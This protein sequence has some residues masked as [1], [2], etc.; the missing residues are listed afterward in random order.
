MTGILLGVNLQAQQ[1]NHLHYVDPFIGTTVSNVLTKWGNNG[2]CYPGGVAPSGSMQLSPETRVVGARGYN[3]ADSSIYYFSCLGHMG[4]FPK[5]SSGRLYIM[6]LKGGANFEAGKSSLRFSHKK[7]T[8]RPGY[9]KVYFDDQQIT[10]EA[11]ATT[12]TGI[13][14]FTFDGDANPQIFVGD[15]GEIRAISDKII[16]AS[17]FNAVINFSEGYTDKKEVKGGWL[18]SFPKAKTGVKMITLKLSRSSV[19]S[20]SAQYNIDK[21]AGN[22]SFDEICARTSREWAKL[23]SVVDLNDNNEQNKTVFYTALYHSLLLPWVA[24]DA[25]GNYRG[26]NG[27]IYKKTGQNQYEAF[28]PWDTFRSLHPLL[29]LLYPQKQQD[30]I[31]SMLDI[32][33][34]SGH[35]PTE[36]MTG[37]HAIP[38]IVDSYLKGIKGFDKDFAYKAMKKDLVDGPFV[39]SDME[40]YHQKGYVPF[41]KPESVTRTVEYAYDDW[42]LSQFADKVMND[43]LTYQLLSNRGFNYRNLLN[44]DELFMLPRNGDEFK[45]QPGT[46]GYKEG[47]KWVYSYF[48]PQNGKDLINMTGGNEQFA[49][50]LDSALR[51][52]VI[53]F[54][55]ETVFH[56]PYL[57]NQAGKPWLTQKW[58]KDIMLHRFNATPGG[59]PGNDDLGSTSSWYIFSSL[60]IYPVCPGR[61]LYAIGAPLFKSATLYLPNGKK[62]VISSNNSVLKNNYV[63]SLRINGKAWQQLILPHSVLMSGGTMTFNMG[64]E[65]GSW[66]A[67]KDPIVLSTTQ[68]NTAFNIVN[69][70]VSKKSVVPDEPLVINFKLK[71]TGG[72]GIKTVKLL[73]EGKPYAYKN[74]LV[75][76]GQTLQDSIVFRLY[77][78]GKSILKLDNTVPFI[79]EV[80]LPEK[81][82]ERP[83]EISGLEVKPMIRL[84][85]NQQIRYMIKNTGGLKQTFI[86]PVILNDSVVFNDNIKLNTGEAKIISHNIT[87]TQKGF[88]YLKIDTAKTIYIVYEDGIESLLLDFRSIVPGKAV[89]DSSGFHNNGKIIS[90]SLANNKDRLLFGDS[91]YVEVANSP[92]LNNMGESITMMGWVYPM[93]NEKGLV[94]IITKGDNHVLQMTDNKTLTFFAGGWGRGDCTVNLPVDW[95]QHWHHIAGICNGKKL[96]VYIDGVLAGTTL[97][98]VSAD[99]SVNNKWTLGRNEE[100]PSERV[101]HGYINRVKVFKAALSVNDIKNIVSSEKQ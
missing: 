37:N 68:K 65:P 69:Y 40:V 64:K 13:F 18:F 25:E 63:Q 31:L 50:R 33:K 91:T 29:T 93:G 87:V 84:K 100:F 61:P 11:T 43:K 88:K 83:F 95:Q 16:H 20:N 24:D 55:N 99:L 26:S 75:E 56:L 41:T 51:N 2:G 86:I 28:S 72:K 36:S 32:Y 8:A 62:F 59:L 3:Y 4:G 90:G 101:F 73:V 79:V 10:A 6:P 98:E 78:V 7:E 89:T 47:D 60:G 71:N 58:M 44:K 53:L 96:Y 38:I 27:K 34:Q 1:I 82:R 54:D 46:S 39:Q 92:A 30:V 21:E 80:K 52:N 70:S 74:C 14:R 22:L 67:N 85:E 15:G 66:P 49:A 42:A 94:D 76:P 97:L 17:N 12:R 19:S 77:P 45:L 81:P 48:V 5:G 57:F 9:Y 23:L 35:L